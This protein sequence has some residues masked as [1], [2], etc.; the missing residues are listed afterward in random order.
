MSDGIIH[1][2]SSHVDSAPGEV[3][4]SGPDGVAVSMTPEAAAKTGGKLID[5]AAEAK[6]KEDLEAGIED[7][8]LRR[9]GQ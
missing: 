3:M 2:D 7:R 6:G 1:K 4:V 5:H 8:R 9:E